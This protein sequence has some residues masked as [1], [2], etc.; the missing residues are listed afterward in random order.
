MDSSL[1]GSSTHGISQARIL[2]CCHFLLQGIFRTQES[3]PCLLCLLYWQAG[4]LP[5]A[6]PGKPP[7]FPSHEYSP[8]FPYQHVT[9]SNSLGYISFHA[10]LMLK[11]CFC[12]EK[13]YTNLYFR[14]WVHLQYFFAI[15]FCFIPKCVLFISSKFPILLHQVFATVSLYV[16]R[17]LNFSWD[18]YFFI[19][20]RVFP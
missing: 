16:Y 5:L 4:S 10:F 3:N 18:C 9:S 11:K 6:L 1:P 15:K 2:E 14:L 19:L 7:T 17:S 12:K 8:P 13:C 20:H